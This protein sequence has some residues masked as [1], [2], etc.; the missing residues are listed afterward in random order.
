M[1][2]VYLARDP[3]LDRQVAVKVISPELAGDPTAQEQFYREAQILASLRSNAVAQ[4][5]AFGPHA[6]GHFFAM[7]YVVGR[8]LES[9]LSDYRLRGAFAPTT[10]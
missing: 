3:A 2:V 8:D 1:G 6:G 10:P 9:I 7:E 4:I 5:H